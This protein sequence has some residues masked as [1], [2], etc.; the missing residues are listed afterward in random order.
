MITTF[1]LEVIT[2]RPEWV[3]K[4]ESGDS[5][6]GLS[7]GIASSQA[8]ALAENA[9]CYSSIANTGRYQVG[10]GPAERTR[11]TPTGGEAISTIASTLRRITACAV[12]IDRSTHLIECG[13]ARRER[14]RHRRL[15]LR[16]VRPRS[17]TRTTGRPIL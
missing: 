2:V 4:M 5:C 6:L 9:P 15:F 10:S 13:V 17:S 7:V 16:A 14:L 1:R 3:D 12:A 11:E 8:A